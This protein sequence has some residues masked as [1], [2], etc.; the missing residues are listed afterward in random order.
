MREETTGRS[1]G[2]DERSAASPASGALARSR[3]IRIDRFCEM[4][5]SRTG[6]RYGETLIGLLAAFVLL[7]V[8]PG[9]SLLLFPYFRTTA[10]Q[11]LRIVLAFDITLAFA[12]AG[13]FVIF[14]RRHHALR[15]WLQGQRSAEA[16]V[17]A[18]ES[19]VAVFPRTVA[20]V[21]GWYAVWCIPSAIYTAD[22]V[23]ISWYGAV[24]YIVVLIFLV[25]GVTVFGYLFLE[26]ALRPVVREIAS[27]LP[28]EF[29]PPQRTVS[30]STKLLVLLPAINLFTGMVVAM[31]STNSLGLQDRLA[32]TAG[33]AL[34]VSVTIAFGLTLMF[35]HALLQRLDDLREGIR[36]VDDGD[37]TVRVP[38]LAGDEMDEVGQSFNRM[39]A[40]LEEREVL[41]E[42]NVEL[43]SALQASLVDVRRQAEE[44]RDSRARIV[45]AGNAERRRVERDLHDGAQ[46]YLVLL[47]LKLG[48]ARRAV[49]QDPAAVAATLDELRVDLDRALAELR[50]LA[51][52]IYPPLLENEG[53][54]GALGEAVRRAAIPASMECDGAGRYP[55][56]LEAAVYFCCLEAL[57]NAAK[58][59][60]DGASARVE[61]GERDGMLQFA[62]I[63]DGRGYDPGV[64]HESA[65]VQ[66]MTDRMGALG[67]S[68][69]IESAPGRGTSVTGEVPLRA[70][71]DG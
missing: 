70:R 45:A 30:L 13:A 57:Q 34:L 39:V 43:D 35:R 12:G 10:D 8:V 66:N 25:I 22:L 21:A 54:P 38:Y 4:L 7:V 46:Q 20:V 55:P 48:L 41:R 58:H 2:H 65:G 44:L 1:G 51:H 6:P 47:G 36:R 19:A 68:L 29:E 15:A 11:Y 16:A 67:G 53:L 17:N 42:H 49:D 71:V 63:D 61:L 40:G 32:V 52:G 37:L 60:G 56:E 59:A 31:V 64:A 69:S 50:D 26:Q 28:D 5:Y 23:Q 9:Y 33:A 14:A 62:V 27:R 24:L 3:N 18:W